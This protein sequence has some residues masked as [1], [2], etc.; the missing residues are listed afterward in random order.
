MEQK[1]HIHNF[2]LLDLPC[3]LLQQ[4]LAELLT[5]RPI[6][7]LHINPDQRRQPGIQTSILRANRRLYSEGYEILYN[8]PFETRLLKPRW[9][10]SSANTNPGHNDSIPPSAL[11]RLKYLIVELTFGPRGRGECLLGMS[12][13]DSE[14][15]LM[16]V[17]DLALTLKR[18][19]TLRE[20]HLELLNA[21]TRKSGPK[22][23]KSEALIVQ[24]SRILM[25]LAYLREEAKVTVG[26]FDTIEFVDSFAVYR[27]KF[28]GRELPW[29]E[30]NT[31]I[32]WGR[33]EEH[34]G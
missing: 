19:D 12:E 6:A 3:E 10:V 11:E 30:N 8:T 4:V 2:R 7:L 20:L 27:E 5:P 1:D 18:G 32:E 25:P 21:K 34:Y 26:G 22:T 13:I 28:K 14:E 16:A 31:M 24:M 9:N 23:F 15:L 17:E 29:A 33:D